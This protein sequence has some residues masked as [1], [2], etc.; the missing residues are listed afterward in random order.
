M[1]FKNRQNK[2]AL[3]QTGFQKRGLSYH[4]PE[5]WKIPTRCLRWLVV[6][7]KLENLLHEHVLKS[8]QHQFRMLCNL[9]LSL[10]KYVESDLTL[11]CPSL[12]DG[13]G[14]ADAQTNYCLCL[15]MT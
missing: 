10:L 6:L 8:K 11:W 7:S 2:S 5:R 12:G 14:N 13:L 1:K 9:H 4:Y 3:K 15:I